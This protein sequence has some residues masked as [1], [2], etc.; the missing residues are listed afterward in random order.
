MV[1]QLTDF[2]F[3]GTAQTVE[4]LECGGLLS[5]SIF[6]RH[7]ATGFRLYG[8]TC[9]DDAGGIPDEKPIDERHTL[10]SR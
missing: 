7:G 5:V 9:Q 8:A 2:A 10:G 6:A 1:D 3:H 4:R